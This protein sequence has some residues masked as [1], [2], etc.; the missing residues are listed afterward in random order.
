MIEK[1]LSHP[2]ERGERHHILPRCM[3]GW[4]GENIVKL[5]AR[6]HFVV[7]ALLARAFPHNE[8]LSYAFWAMCNQS[9]KYHERKR[10]SSLL[11]ERAREIRAFH[12]SR[13][14]TG[15]I[16]SDETRKKM[17]E[18]AKHRKTQSP[19][20]LPGKLVSEETRRK[21]SELTRN[22]PRQE[23]NKCGRWVAH[24]SFTQHTK[25][26]ERQTQ[27]DGQWT[28]QCPSCH[29]NISY[30]RKNAYER[31]VKRNTKCRSCR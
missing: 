19:A 18:S 21:L 22:Q 15:R 20:C 24:R 3:G 27:L 26:C 28:R 30:A 8:K 2:S 12:I 6:E 14:L 25:A 29:S 4:D 11:Y 13:L 9:N 5:T 17:S 31:A 7:H 23:C 16:F 10:P 1:R